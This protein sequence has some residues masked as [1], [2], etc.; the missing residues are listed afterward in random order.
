M[1][2][3]QLKVETLP[4]IHETGR[5][6][7][8]GLDSEQGAAPLEESDGHADEEDR[9]GDEEPDKDGDQSEHLHP[10]DVCSTLLSVPC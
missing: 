2:F 5:G 9:D 4:R 3:N 1:S 10:E 8:P 7:G 6:A